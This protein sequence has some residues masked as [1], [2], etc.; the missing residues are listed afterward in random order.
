[1]VATHYKKDDLLNCWTSSLD[2]QATTRTFTKDTALSEH[3][4]G[5]ALSEHGRGAALS[6]LGRGAAWYV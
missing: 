3:G 4:R 2:I 6:E 1:M 5:V